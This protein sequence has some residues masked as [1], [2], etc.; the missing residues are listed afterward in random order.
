MGKQVEYF[1]NKGVRREIVRIHTVGG[2]TD[3]IDP[4]GKSATNVTESPATLIVY[5]LG[6]YEYF[7]EAPVGTARSTAAW[8][9]MRHTIATSDI[10]YAGTGLAEHAA[11]DAATVEALTYTLGA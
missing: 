11:N 2:N 6:A 4:G 8:R 10:V 3:T 7:C 9:V 5:T 1:D